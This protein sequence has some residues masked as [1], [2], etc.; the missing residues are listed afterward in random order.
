MIIG[1]LLIITST[2]FSFRYIYLKNYEKNKT[3]QIIEEIFI[4]EQVIESETKEEQ[5]TIIDTPKKETILTNEYLGYIEFSNYGVKRLIT[6]GTD[7]ETLDKNLAGL[8]D[9]SASLDDK[10]GNIIMAGH[11]TSNVFQKLHYMKIG[12]EI[13]IVSHKDTYYFNITEKHVIDS[14]NFTYFKYNNKEK[15]LTLITCKNNSNQRLIVIAKIKGVK[16]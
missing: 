15:I 1:F 2:L 16:N 9:M 5:P 10:V 8:S 11:S 7:K 14:D 13:K 6:N 12:D 3:E 4:E